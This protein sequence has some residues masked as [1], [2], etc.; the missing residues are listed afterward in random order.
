MYKIHFFK[1]KA[2]IFSFYLINSLAYLLVKKFPVILSHQ[3]E[4][5]EEGPSKRIK[6]GVI[7]VW[8]LSCFDTEETLRALPARVTRPVKGCLLLDIDGNLR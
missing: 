8:V 3:P 1:C 4:E 6:A 2:Y 7:V 5:R